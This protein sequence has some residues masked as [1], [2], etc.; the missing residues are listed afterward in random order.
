MHQIKIIVS[1]QTIVQE[2]R[3][4]HEKGLVHK[5]LLKL[6]SNALSDLEILTLVSIVPS[7]LV[8]RVS[9]FN[10]DFQGSIPGPCNNSWKN[11]DPSGLNTVTPL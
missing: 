2:T 11:I 6:S 3:Q 8:V 4:L 9:S 7:R 10:A 5:Q 1:E